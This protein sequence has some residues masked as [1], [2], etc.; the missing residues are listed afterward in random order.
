MDTDDVR[1]EFLSQQVDF[2]LEIESLL[3]KVKSYV[4]K[5]CITQF[6]DDVLPDKCWDGY[7][8]RVL[9]DNLIIENQKYSGKKYFHPTIYVGTG[10][11]NNYYG[12]TGNKSIFDQSTPEL[13]ALK[14]TLEQH[15]TSRWTHWI[16][17]RYF[18]NRKREELW[19]ISL[20]QE[21]LNSFYQ[22]WSE[23]FWSFAESIRE[24]IENLNKSLI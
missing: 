15:E 23:E 7:E 24:S 21:A 8:I 20:S 14:K 13:D 16:G 17:Y 18:I 4:Y 12:V 10:D 9:G 11:R 6:R 22:Q 5:K 19:E 2:L 1:L 3:P